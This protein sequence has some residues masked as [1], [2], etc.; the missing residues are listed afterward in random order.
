MLYPSTRNLKSELH[1]QRSHHNCKIHT[2]NSNQCES[3]QW[4]STIAHF[5]RLII[6]SSESSRRLQSLVTNFSRINNQALTTI[7]RSHIPAADRTNTTVFSLHKYRAPRGSTSSS[8]IREDL[9][10][11]NFW[12]SRSATSKPH[13]AEG[14]V[15][16]PWG[17]SWRG[18]WSMRRDA[19]R[20][21]S[22]HLADRNIHLCPNFTQIVFIRA[23]DV[24]P[25]ARKYYSDKGSWIIE[26]SLSHFFW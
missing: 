15:P 23:F 21:S 14:M 6:N 13:Q 1:W 16:F 25:D 22:S 20:R 10:K 24:R 5:P 26:K 8:T 9:H 3:T 11:V 17:A 18:Q 12:S 7:K 2:R 4:P 19:I